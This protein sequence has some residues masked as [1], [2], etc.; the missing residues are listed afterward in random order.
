MKIRLNKTFFTFLVFLCFSGGSLGASD[1]KV[2]KVRVFCPSPSTI[3]FQEG[4]DRLVGFLTIV[5]A[6]LKTLE[7]S[8][9]SECRKLDQTEAVAYF[10]QEGVIDCHYLS[11]SCAAGEVLYTNKANDLFSD[12]KFRNSDGD[13]CVGDEKQ[14]ELLCTLQ[15]HVVEQQRALARESAFK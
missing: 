15:E 3:K 5:G 8:T 2:E 4:K 1:S 14:C 12:C 6:A 7:V 11:H 10:P 13:E 9:S